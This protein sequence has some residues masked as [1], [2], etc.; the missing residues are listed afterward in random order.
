MTQELLEYLD[1][2]LKFADTGLPITVY[3]LFLSICILVHF[4]M[5]SIIIITIFFI[6]KKKILRIIELLLLL[7]FPLLLCH[8]YNDSFPNDNT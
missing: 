2:G 7:L 8:Y 1:N 3:D 5:S 6:I 4:G